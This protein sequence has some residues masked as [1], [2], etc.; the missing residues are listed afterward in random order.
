MDRAYVI[1]H[2]WHHEGLS[3]RKIARDLQRHDIAVVGYEVDRAVPVEIS[4]HR[5][6]RCTQTIEQQGL[7]ARAGVAIDGR[8]GVG[9]GRRTRDHQVG[10]AVLVDIVHHR[11]PGGD[12]LV[13]GRRLTAHPLVSD[14]LE[15]NARAVEQDLNV[16]TGERLARRPAVISFVQQD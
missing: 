9:L 7:E 5:P 11:E 2:K 1:K 6:T 12:L 16:A 4:R 10:T 15:L 14:V 8:R 13:A 3:I